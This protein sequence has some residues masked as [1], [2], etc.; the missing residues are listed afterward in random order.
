MAHA[1]ASASGKIAEL[2]R[3]QPRVAIGGFGLTAVLVL[4]LLA[5]IANQNP[6]F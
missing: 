3:R 2:A 5:I 4:E 6:F 1:L